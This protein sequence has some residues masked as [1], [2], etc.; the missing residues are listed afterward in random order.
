MK[1]VYPYGASS[2]SY[3]YDWSQSEPGDAN[4][5]EPGDDQSAVMDYKIECMEMVTSTD[6][7]IELL[8]CLQVTNRLSIKHC[9]FT[10]DLF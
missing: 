1:Q 7:G 2:A 4:P 9:P 5:L 10:F 6:G 3:P 8:N